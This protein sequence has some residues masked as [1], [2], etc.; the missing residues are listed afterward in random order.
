MSLDSS[1]IRK[2]NIDDQLL[3]RFNLRSE[4]ICTMKTH[5]FLITH[6]VRNFYIRGLLGFIFFH[7]F[8]EQRG[9]S[10]E[11]FLNGLAPQPIL[12]LNPL[13][14]GGLNYRNFSRQVWARYARTILIIANRPSSTLYETDCQVSKQKVEGKLL[15]NICFAHVRICVRRH[16]VRGQENVKM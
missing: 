10:Y 5:A 1:K 15:W 7:R 14:G 11:L 13:R 16:D 6:S 8:K 2:T 4:C 9:I 3:K 12:S